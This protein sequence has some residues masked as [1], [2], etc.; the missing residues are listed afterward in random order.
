MP[1]YYVRPDGN[2]ANTGLGSDVGQAWATVAHAL[3]ATGT[4][5]GVVGG[6][7]IY[8]APGKYAGLTIGVT[9]SSVLTIIGDPSG[10]QFGYS[11]TPG[12]VYISNVNDR[13][14]TTATV[15]ITAT[16]KNNFSFQQLVISGV[17]TTSCH[18]W[19]LNKCHINQYTTANSP[20]S[21]TFD[22]G[23]NANTTISNSSVLSLSASNIGTI[24]LTCGNHTST[25]TSNINIYNVTCVPSITNS[26]INIV[27]NNATGIL[28]SNVF[29]VQPS[30]S[31]NVTGTVLDQVR[32]Q[33]SILRTLLASTSGS[34]VE[35]YN[36]VLGARTLVGSGANSVAVANFLQYGDYLTQC[37]VGAFSQFAP[38]STV[39]SQLVGFGT[40]L[41]APTTDYFGRPYLQPTI[42]HLSASSIGTIGTYVPADRNNQV[43]TITPGSVGQSIQVYLGV[44]G[45]TA[46]SPALT[47]RYNRSRSVSVSIPLLTRTI[48]QPWVAG[49]FAE[50][51]PVGMPGVYRLDLPNEALLGG[52]DDC[53]VVVRG[54]SGTNGAVITIDLRNY[55][56]VT[57][58]GYKLISDQMGANGILDVIKGSS[59][60]VKLQMVDVHNKPVP[61]G[62]AACTVEVYSLN[63]LVE[64]YPTVIQYQ[65]NGEL[66]FTLDTTVTNTPG[67]Y[68]IY[69]VRNNGGS[70]TV[71]YG[72]MK[73]VVGNL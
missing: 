20:L 39:F 19:T 26:G 2:N 67:S 56:F 45:L 31:I 68:N 64:S 25:Y 34:L 17:T 69:V 7:T 53:T 13:A 30:N 23:V 63:N 29:C 9:P 22:A 43:I 11:L 28:I 59:I 42:G 32:V 71:L 33:N 48:T 47:A 5:S 8:V 46:T 60:T 66:T 41:N 52:A 18:N 58:T 1:T 44:V 70:D 50:V 3:G 61:I 72:P 21:M 55:T 62:T 49:G 24:S 73:L 12:P 54:A 15:A 65:S 6:D 35:D 14:T 4:A 37:G 51:D 10:S 36:I 40:S 38:A 57:T 16:S 27:A